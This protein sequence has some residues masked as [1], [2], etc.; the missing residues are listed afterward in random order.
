MQTMDDMVK[1]LLK[2]SPETYWDLLNA[3]TWITTHVMD[4]KKEAT[5][6]IELKTYP[7]IKKLAIKESM[8][9]A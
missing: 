1:Y 8:A 5:H 9:K 4:R 3:A 7:M 6:K 2:D